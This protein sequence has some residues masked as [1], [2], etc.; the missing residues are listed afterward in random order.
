MQNVLPQNNFGRVLYF[1]LTGNR[2]V[3][4]QQEDKPIGKKKHGF[5]QK[6]SRKKFLFLPAY[7]NSSSMILG[8]YI[9]ELLYEHNCVV[10]PGWGGFIA[11]RVSAQVN[12]VSNKIT[13]PGKRIAFN[14][15]LNLNDGILA[16][17]VATRESISYETSLDKIQKMLLELRQALVENRSIH[18][19]T[20]GTFYVDQDEVMTFHPEVDLN[21]SKDDFGL[22]TIAA[23]PVTRDENAKLKQKIRSRVEY[24]KPLRTSATLSLSTRR[25][26]TALAACLVFGAIAFAGFNMELGKNM[27]LSGISTWFD[28]YTLPWNRRHNLETETPMKA[29]HSLPKATVSSMVTIQNNEENDSVYQLLPQNFSSIAEARIFV[30]EMKAQG[31]KD[32]NFSIKENGRTWVSVML[33]PNRVEAENHLLGIAK[34]FPDARILAKRK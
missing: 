14:Q 16:K 34:T 2:Q 32:A 11:R 15:G 30:D 27:S 23:V 10:V 13:P 31:L 24:R 33:Y 22:V 1:L 4:V 5:F 20:V 21:V 8:K 25:S 7:S 18:L 6:L 3:F 12:P 9:N 19:E 17:H 26:I 28:E 29:K